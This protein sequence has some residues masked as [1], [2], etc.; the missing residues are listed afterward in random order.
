MFQGNVIL[1][2]GQDLTM[3]VL[4][5]DAKVTRVRSLKGLDLLE[6]LVGPNA[7]VSR[8]AEQYLEGG[9]GH[10]AR[11]VRALQGLVSRKV[12]R[13]VDKMKWKWK[14]KRK[15]QAV[16]PGSILMVLFQS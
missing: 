3:A 7:S 12:I 16:C 9:L 8:Q 10:D 4:L 14:K 15:I 6:N 13:D 5:I 11:V 2:S 1:C